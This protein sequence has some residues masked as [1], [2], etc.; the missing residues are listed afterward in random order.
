[1]SDILAGGS[2]HCRS[3]SSR[4]KMARLS[5]E[6]KSERLTRAMEASKVV[7]KERKES[8]PYRKKYGSEYDTLLRLAASA[9]QRCEN[10]NSAAYADYG[11]RGIGFKFSGVRAFAEW[12]LDNLGP[13]PS[14]GHTVDRVDNNRGYEPGNLRWATRSEQARN[15]RAYRRTERGEQIRRIIALRPDLTYETIRTWL[16]DGYTEEQVLER[17][18]YARARV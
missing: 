13:K 7:A 5:D 4:A 17:R 1:V 9:R 11:G 6:Q 15:K 16:L 12:V 2:P 3:C 8:N 18:K 14:R 10:K